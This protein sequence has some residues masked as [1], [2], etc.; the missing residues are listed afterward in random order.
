MTGHGA[1]PHDVAVT[2]TPQRSER[3]VVKGA[4]FDVLTP[5]QAADGRIVVDQTVRVTTGRRG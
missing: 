3:P 1:W 2:E 4:A 5:L